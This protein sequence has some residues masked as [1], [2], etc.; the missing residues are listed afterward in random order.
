MTTE[1]QAPEAPADATIRAQMIIGGEAVDA[2]DGQTFE[3]VNPADGASFATAPLGGKADV[4]RAVAAAKAAFPKFSQTSKAERI[5]LLKRIIACYKD[6]I[7]DIAQAVSA[8][9][10]APSPWRATA[11]RRQASPT[12][13]RP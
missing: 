10:G 11:R 7:E 1:S 12:L 8:E 3:I 5:A 2:A 4:D 9:M 6:R 13:N